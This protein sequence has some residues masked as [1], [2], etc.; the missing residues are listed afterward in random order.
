MAHDVQFCIPPR[1][2]GRSDVEFVVKKDDEL[3]GT[4]KISNGSIV[5]F[6]KNA[7]IGH[8]MSWLKFDELMVDHAPGK[9][10]R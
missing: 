1:Q 2:L 8:R 7:Q 6:P 4:L 9:E 10:R 5:W 3:L